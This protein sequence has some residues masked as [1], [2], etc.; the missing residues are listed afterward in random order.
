MKITWKDIQKQLKDEDIA[1]EFIST[2]EDDGNYNTYHALIV[3]KH[4]PSPTMITL[5]SET[6]LEEL[7][8]TTSRQFHDIVGELLWKPII[9]QYNMAKNIYF[10]PDRILNL[11]PIE[12]FNVG[13]NKN[14]FEY[15]NMYRLSSTKEL[16]RNNHTP[17][18]NKAVLYGGLD[19]NQLKEQVRTKNNRWRGIKDRGGFEPLFNTLDEI[20]EIESLLVRSNIS[21]TLFSGKNGTEDSFLDLSSQNINMMH[22][23]THGMYISPN[24]IDIKKKR[25]ILIS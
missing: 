2:I 17:K 16:I 22:L 13:S 19:Y 21:T 5:Y 12:Y 10:S 3:D 14:M 4:S 15:Y 23:A 20:K 11:L 6:N 8:K 24:S 9:S 7:K 18:H 1:I 25:I